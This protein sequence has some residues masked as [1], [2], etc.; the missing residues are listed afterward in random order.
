[1]KDTTEEEGI[2]PTENSVRHT[3]YGHIRGPVVGGGGRSTGVLLYNTNSVV[4]LCHVE[5]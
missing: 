2:T 1:M 5:M 3:K 4:R